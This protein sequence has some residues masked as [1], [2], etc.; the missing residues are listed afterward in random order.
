MQISVPDKHHFSTTQVSKICRVAPR[1]VAKWCDNNLLKH[2]SLPGSNHRRILREDLVS[3]MARNNICTDPE[4]ITD[5]EKEAEEGS[6][7]RWCYTFRVMLTGNEERRCSEHTR[8]LFGYN[9]I[10]CEEV[11]TP[12]GFKEFREGLLGDGFT[13]LDIRRQPYFKPQVVH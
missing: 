2:Y 5:T 8:E 9:V 1:T 6:E 11:K 7:T 3:F 4:P 12:E 13:L 10:T